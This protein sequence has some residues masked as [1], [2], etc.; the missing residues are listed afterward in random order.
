MSNRKFAPQI[1]SMSRDCARTACQSPRRQAA[2]STS[3]RSDLQF[4][5]L[6]YRPNPVSMWTFAAIARRFEISLGA[7]AQVGRQPVDRTDQVGDL[8][9]RHRVAS[10]GFWR[11]R[12]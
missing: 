12:Q 5:V 11:E 8:S 4:V 3:T 10:A 6:A 9:E 2:S 1:D 7:A